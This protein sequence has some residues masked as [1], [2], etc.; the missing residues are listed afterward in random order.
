MCQRLCGYNPQQVRIL[1]NPRLAALL[2]ILVMAISIAAVSQTE[3]YLI[4]GGTQERLAG[5]AEEAALFG[6]FLSAF[7]LVLV[8]VFIALHETALHCVHYAIGSLAFLLATLL[9]SLIAG[10][11]V[12]SWKASMMVPAISLSLCFVILLSAA[13]WRGFR[14][15]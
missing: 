6:L 12:H 2:C 9:L 15:H 8:A 3:A 10:F 4:T 13:T 1:R 14:Q 5:I 11:T 7:L